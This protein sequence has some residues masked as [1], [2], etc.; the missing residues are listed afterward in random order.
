M[1][2]EAFGF[3]VLRCSDQVIRMVRPSDVNVHIT[4]S[5]PYSTD[6][7]SLPETFTKL[8]SK[9]HLIVTDSQLQALKLEAHRIVAVATYLQA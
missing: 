4:T 1:Q 7:N 3:G 2:V 6:V 9:V 5:T 8:A